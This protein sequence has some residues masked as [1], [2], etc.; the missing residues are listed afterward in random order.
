MHFICV[1][2]LCAISVRAHVFQITH[3]Q[4]KQ[5]IKPGVS[6]VPG[7]FVFVGCLAETS[8][9]ATAETEWMRTALC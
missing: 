8:A 2:C 7:V 9:A 1:W 5:S 4:E 6:E 3:P